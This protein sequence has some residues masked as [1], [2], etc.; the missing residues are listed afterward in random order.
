M[1]GRLERLGLGD[2]VLDVRDGAS[3]NRRVARELGVV[4]DRAR[5]AKAADT[6]S[7]QRTVSDRRARLVAHCSA[8]HDKRDPWGVSAFDTQVALARLC[9]RRTPPTSRVR[10]HGDEL[11][12]IGRTR[13]D[14][15]SRS[16]TQIASL[17][18]W[19]AGETGDPW[20]GARITSPQEAEQALEIASRRGDE[21]MD[22]TRQRLEEAMREVGL[23]DA[24]TPADWGRALSLVERVRQTLDIFR[25]C[26]A[27]N[28][29]V[30]EILMVVPMAALEDE[31]SPW[32]E[33]G[34]VPENGGLAP[35]P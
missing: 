6:A 3:N 29:E 7:A 2:L 33:P 18:A 15:L 16:L 11:T 20:Y 23:P 9:E 5:T 12:A 19:V 14:E 26:V 30:H 27:R 10:I 17:G 1:I 25:V 21:R 34:A 31:T 32:V 4:L 24:Q 13:V 22:A 28:R 8:L 35:H